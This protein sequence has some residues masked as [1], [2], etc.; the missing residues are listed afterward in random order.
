MVHFSCFINRKLL[1]LQKNKIMAVLN[2]TSREF[3]SQQAHVFELADQGEKVIIRRNKKQ[4]YTLVPVSD[5]DFTITP[6]LQARI[7]KA[8]AEIKAGECITVRGKEELNA[9]LTSL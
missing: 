1:S 5:D 6:E 3:R 4:A 8:R 7:D 2:F 9:Y